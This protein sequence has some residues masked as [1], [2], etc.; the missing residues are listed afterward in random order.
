MAK[1]GAKSKDWR[2]LPVEKW[3]A[4]TFREYLKHL[5]MERFGIPYVTN[6]YG[7]EGRMLKNTWEEYGK[8]A[9]KRFIERCIEEYKPKA[10]YP[11]VSYGFMYSYMRERVMKRVLKE[12]YCQKATENHQTANVNDDDLSDWI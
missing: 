5:H 9:T 4:T 10:E 6:S 8:P 2:N 11:G 1:N 12:L 3:N 7:A